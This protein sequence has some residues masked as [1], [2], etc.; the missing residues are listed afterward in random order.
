MAALLHA[1]L[2]CP[3]Q[4]GRRVLFIFGHTCVRR[5][6]STIFI[7]ALLTPIIFHA[8]LPDRR[9]PVGGK[10]PTCTLIANILGCAPAD[11]RGLGSGQL[12][13][14]WNL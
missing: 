14:G 13:Y 10:S 11:R 6:P 4:P 7:L 8:M 2:P 1:V 3:S 9:A 5:L 12:L